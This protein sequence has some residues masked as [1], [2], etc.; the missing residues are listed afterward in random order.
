[1][2]YA[3]IV[4]PIANC[5]LVENYDDIYGAISFMQ[6]SLYTSVVTVRL[7][8]IPAGPYTLAFHENAIEDTDWNS[9]GDV[10]MFGDDQE[11]YS[12]QVTVEEPEN[13]KW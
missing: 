7:N 13:R 12:I 6:D 9:G 2:E 3:R 8:N 11:E 5:Q 10:N 1:M 4:S